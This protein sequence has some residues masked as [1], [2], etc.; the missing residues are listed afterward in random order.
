MDKLKVCSE[1]NDYLMDFSSIDMDNL[2]IPIY[3]DKGRTDLLSKIQFI[4]QS[5]QDLKK[6]CKCDYGFIFSDEVLD[7]GKSELFCEK[8]IASVD[9]IEN[10]S[11]F[12][13]IVAIGLYKDF[14]Q[15]KVLQWI[16]F[17]KS[18]KKELFFLVGRDM[19]SLSWI[20]AKQFLES[21]LELPRAV[22]S[23]RNLGEYRKKDLNWQLYD[24]DD[25]QTK[26]IKSIIEQTNWSELL[27]HGHGKEDYLHLGDF[28]LCG[29]NCSAEG[30]GGFVPSCGNGMGCFK[31]D[32]KVINLN[33]VRAEK[34]LLISCSNFPFYDCKLY[35]SKYNIILNAID[36]FAKN[37]V[38]SITVQSAD[39][40]ELDELICDTSINNIGVRLHEKLDDMQPFAS[41]INIGLPATELSKKEVVGTHRLT[42]LTKTILSRISLYV[43]SGMLSKEHPIYKL[44]QKIL[45]DYNPITRRGIYGVTDRQVSE[46]EQSVVNRVNPLTKKIGE[47]MVAS[48][49]DELHGFSGYSALRSIKDKNSVVVGICSCGKRS[50]R[51]EY[52]PEIPTIFRIESI[53]CY[54]CG[55]KLT[56]MTEMPQVVF[57]CDERNK[58]GLVVNYEFS[59]TPQQRGDVFWTIL[60]PSA[61]EDKC[62]TKRELH[63]IKFKSIRTEKI[64]GKIEFDESIKIQGYWMKVLVMQNAGIS[65]SRAFFNLVK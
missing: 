18:Q 6:I 53:Y 39:N 32:N 57:S 58:E 43:S 29:A 1:I 41:I 54:K 9:E 10:S 19:S 38:A 47:L 34:I 42:P 30:E 65:I 7:L 12:Q 21:N 25:Y 26:D 23:L 15:G 45:Q 2:M 50:Y 22:F 63:K 13:T 48:L 60:L 5:N 35:N 49:N 14:T 61:I 46:F 16:D 40:P 4:N 27:F 64:V 31:E 17:C 37:I 51:C 8:W 3:V 52:E 11:E 59:I 55:E 33:T 36:G 24:G 62:I 56:G 28:T 20:I 44:S